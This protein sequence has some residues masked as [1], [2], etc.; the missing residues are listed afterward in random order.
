MKDWSGISESGIVGISMDNIKFGRFI[1]ESRQAKGL[2][3]KQLAAQMGVAACTISQ[4]ENQERIPS[5]PSV[6]KMSAVLHVSTDYLFGIDSIQ[7]ADLSG[8]T[9]QDI[10]LVERLVESMREK[11]KKIKGA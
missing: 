8:L 2:T 6:I 9:E 3:Q 1:R 11:N 7:R 5:P 10:E 4:Y